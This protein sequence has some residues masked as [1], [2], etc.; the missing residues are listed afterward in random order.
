MAGKVV[1]VEM[2]V[3]VVVTGPAKTREAVVTAASTVV[4][5][6]AAKQSDQAIPAKTYQHLSRQGISHEIP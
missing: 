1:V 4:V 3:E 2:K 5:A 6:A